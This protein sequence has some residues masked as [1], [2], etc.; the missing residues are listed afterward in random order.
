MQIYHAAGSPIRAA[1]QTALQLRLENNSWIMGMPS[2]EDTIRGLTASLLWV[3][4]ASRCDDNL[5]IA[6]EPFVAT[7]P[8]GKVCMMSTPHGQRGYWYKQW[9]SGTDYKKFE[10]SADQCPRLK[11][12]FLAGQKELMGQRLFEQEYY[13]S[14]EASE[15]SVFRA[16]VVKKCLREFETLDDVLDNA[17]ELDDEEELDGPAIDDLNFDI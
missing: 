12:T 16:D 8:D 14:F 4:E 9:V 17:L 2:S 15:D 1:S 3:E 6:S 7:V 10:I 5:I 13:N 11:K